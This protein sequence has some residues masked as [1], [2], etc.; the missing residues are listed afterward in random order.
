[1]KSSVLF[2]IFNRPD[3]TQRVFEAIREAKPPKLY[4]SADGPRLN[5]EGEEKKCDDTRK[6]IEMVDWDC[7][8]KTYFR[9]Q[10]QGC[11]IA[12]SSGI[13]W[14]FEQEEE[15]IIL[16]DDCLPNQSFFSFCDNLLEH[17]RN[18]N[19]IGHISGNNFQ[20]G[21]IRDKGSYYFSKFAHIWGWATWRRA[22][23]AYDV[24]FTDYPAFISS[25]QFSN[26][27]FSKKEEAFFR[28][29]ITLINDGVMNTW[30]FQWLFTLW[31][32]HMLSITPQVNLV[33]N[34]GFGDVNATHTSGNNFLLNNVGTNE[35]NRII[36]PAFFTPNK[37]ADSYTFNQ[38]YSP[39]LFNKLKL[40][41]AK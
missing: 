24:N 27:G 5:V 32:Q 15:G 22:W 21:L 30:D 12:V 19:R 9:K 13:D 2:L 35:I 31:H 23:K 11:K 36:H 7:Q 38:K 37:K 17:Y 10:N 16:E 41:F 40:L 29:K 4:V 20:D 18:D 28:K 25:N 34:I 6:I 26:I 39:R 3:S 33:S 1:M 8:V 14:F